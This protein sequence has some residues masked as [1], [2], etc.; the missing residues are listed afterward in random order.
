MTP[1]DPRTPEAEL[2]TGLRAG[3]PKAVREFLE[4]THHP[5]WCMAARVS[6]D[7]DT[8]RD[9]SHEVM[10]GVLHDVKVGRFEYRGPGSFWGWFR[11]RA[12][13]RLLD[14]YRRGRLV[15]EREAPGGSPDELPDA[16][17]LTGA[18]DPADE[19]ERT[20]IRSA[21]E[22]C[23]DR[24]ENENQRR[25][26][27]GLLWE[28]L[29]YEAIARRLEAP[30]N[31]VRAWIRRGRLALRKCLVDSLGLQPGESANPFSGRGPEAGG[32]E[33]P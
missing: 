3:E 24:L 4:R 31:T 27:E 30:L 15:H 16:G 23:L 32:Q 7:P 26:L 11:K 25:A 1:D 33:R 22:R 13:F 20:E 19:L 28:D 12:Y 6:S 8:R 9:W 5:V 10:L 21:V 2:V 14:E 29:P 18:E 17:P